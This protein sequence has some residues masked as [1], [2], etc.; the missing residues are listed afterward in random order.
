[1]STQERLPKVLYVDML[2]AHHAAFKTAGIMKAYRRV[3]VL[4]SFPYRKIAGGYGAA[5]MNA[6]LIETALEFCPN[7]IHLG[8]C[9]NVSGATIKAIKECLDTY[10]IHFY[11]DFRLSPQ[12]WVISI[13]QYADCTIFN[14]DDEE[15]LDRYRSAGLERIGPWW[16]CGTDPEVFYPRDMEKVWDLA[17]MGTNVPLPHS[18]YRIRRQLLETALQEGFSLHI[19]GGI[20]GWRYLKTD[21]HQF[22]FGGKFAEACS[23]ARVTLGVNGVNDV[24]MYASWRRTVNSMASGAFHLTHYVPGLETFF[25]NKK[26]LVWFHDVSE[27]MELIGYYLS[28]E[29][30]REEIAIAGRQ[31]VLAHHTW[32]DRIRRLMEIWQSGCCRRVT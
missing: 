28:H 12:R 23:R 4:K 21:T 6:M 10:V 32:D 22:V 3:A 11:E 5:R 2:T 24:R 9:E 20:G 25:E 18:G 13:G 30:E 14:V 17:F 15:Y 26:H 16:G 29:R 7:L 19:F 8:K 27:A 31:E 1:M